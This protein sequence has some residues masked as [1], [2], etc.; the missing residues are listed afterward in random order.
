[1]ATEDI[2]RDATRRILFDIEKNNAMAYSKLLGDSELL[3][4]LT[5][6]E[7]VSVLIYRLLAQGFI[8]MKPEIDSEGDENFLVS[9]TSFGKAFMDSLPPKEK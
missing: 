4:H 1:M 2:Y 6:V 9:L 5:N 3:R 7:N 8:Q